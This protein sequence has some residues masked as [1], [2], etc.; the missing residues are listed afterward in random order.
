MIRRRPSDLAIWVALT[1]LAVV[2]TALLWRV[3]A[4]LPLRFTYDP[5]EG[6]NAYHA[7]AAMAGTPLYP[8]PGSDFVNNYPPLSFYIVGILGRLTG[9]MVIAGRIV[10]LASFLLL[11]MG[12]F[13]AASRMG[14]NK[15]AAALAALVFAATMLVFTDYVAMDDPQLLAHA[16]AMA[17]FL[18][19]LPERRPPA[20]LAA[21]ALLFTVAFF[22]KHN[23][24][25]MAAATTLWLVWRDRRAGLTL[26]A[27]GLTMGLCGLVLFR[28]T[29]GENLLTVLATAR[30]YSLTALETGLVDWLRVS[31]ILLLATALLWR[32]RNE[33]F[34]R[35]C[36][37]YAGC[38]IAVGGYFLGGAGVDPNVLFDADIALTLCA[39]LAL[40][41]LS[42]VGRR[43]LILLL[44]VPIV[45]GVVAGDTVPRDAVDWRSPNAD[46]A[47]VSE[48]DIAFIADRPG[49]ALCALPSFCY[50]AG[51]PASVDV[52]NLG[53]T[54]AT[55]ARTDADLIR[56]IERKD[57][58]V[59]QLDSDDAAPLGERVRATMR[60]HYRIDHADDCG[61]FYVPK[62]PH[63]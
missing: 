42:A 6:W 50:W 13:A 55:G 28:L 14:A 33:P 43:T 52:F 29:F 54:F 34:V 10:S 7:V 21:A 51:K 20:H 32:R 23:V 19:L 25:V 58:S 62:A 4:A 24:V 35:L 63:V 46:I 26:A 16:V 48:R 40:C 47:E 22:I 57:F 44:P 31:F 41:G 36:L 56:R 49:P 15:R 45:L 1:V 37:I 9:D 8:A 38:G 5:N 17:G 59:I 39:A 27:A 11:S 18:L 61:V 30:R 60:T 53:E 12:I 2:V 3:V